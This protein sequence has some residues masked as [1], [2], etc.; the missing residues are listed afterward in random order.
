MS[1]YIKELLK[2]KEEI[3]ERTDKA[4]KNHEKNEI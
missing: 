1:S 3:K 4:I 2:L